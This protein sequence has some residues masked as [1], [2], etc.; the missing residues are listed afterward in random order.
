VLKEGFDVDCFVEV[1]VSSFEGQ[2]GVDD[3]YDTE[4]DGETVEFGCAVD[5]SITT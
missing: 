2:C 1:G 4:L 3:I 5:V